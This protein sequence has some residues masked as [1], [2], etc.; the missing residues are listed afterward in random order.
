MFLSY[1]I[2]WHNQ[3]AVNVPLFV[4]WLTSN[5]LQTLIIFRKVKYDIVLNFGTG[6]SR[7]LSYG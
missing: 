4:V 6:V 1:N 2:N 5:C 3:S 7:H